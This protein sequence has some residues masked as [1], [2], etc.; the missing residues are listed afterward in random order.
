MRLEQQFT[1]TAQFGH[2]G[3][4][5][6]RR[7]HPRRQTDGAGRATRGTGAAGVAGTAPRP[8]PLA[9]C[10]AVGCAS[11]TIASVKACTN[12]APKPT[13]FARVI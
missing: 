11:L 9:Y 2:K 10:V 5:P 12:G 7:H 1:V 8:L 13:R 6:T 3:P 4:P